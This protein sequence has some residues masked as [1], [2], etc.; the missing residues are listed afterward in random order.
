MKNLFVVDMKY[1][2]YKLIQQAIDAATPGS[3]IKIA[4]GE[5]YENLVIVKDGLKLMPRDEIGDIIL[6]SSKK[7]CITVNLKKGQK[8]SIEGL[9]IFHCGNN[10]GA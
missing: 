7:P 5:Y 6:V 9:K 8:F 2:P 1:G 10:D 4:K 3:N